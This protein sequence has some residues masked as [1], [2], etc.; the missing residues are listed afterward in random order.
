MVSPVAVA[1]PPCGS[2]S[3]IF[4]SMAILSPATNP[5]VVLNVQVLG[6]PNPYTEI[7]PVPI[8][9]PSTIALNSIV[10]GVLYDAAN[11][12]RTDMRQF[13]STEGW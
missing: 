12:T 13:E 6:E 1:V 9:L 5:P 4:I 2:E 7:L 10:T 3:A 11:V 8:F